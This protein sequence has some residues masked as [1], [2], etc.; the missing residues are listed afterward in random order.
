MT[1][2]VRLYGSETV[3]RYYSGT[4][5]LYGSEKV[6]HYDSWTV[7]KTVQQWDSRMV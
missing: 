3:G 5:R 1:G 4:I 6:G 7:A 2:T